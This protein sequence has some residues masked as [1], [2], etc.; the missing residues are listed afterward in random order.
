MDAAPRS[1]FAKLR[2]TGRRLALA[3]FFGGGGF[4][5]FLESASL[6]QAA[7]C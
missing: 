3:A 4:G 6:G 2:W 1:D 7:I 5:C